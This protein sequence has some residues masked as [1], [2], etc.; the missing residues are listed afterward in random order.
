VGEQEV[1]MLACC[2]PV[3]AA[4]LMLDAGVKLHEPGVTDAVELVPPRLTVT[5]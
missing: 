4:L 1:Q 2:E 5:V 3:P